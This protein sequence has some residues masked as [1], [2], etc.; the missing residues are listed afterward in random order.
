MLN[1]RDPARLLKAVP[2]TKTIQYKGRPVYAVPHRTEEVRVLKNLGIEAPAP[3][4]SYYDYPAQFTPMSHQRETV[5]FLTTNPRAYCLHGLGAGKTMCALWSYDWLRREGVVN[6]LLVVSPL[7]TLEPAWGREIFLNM[8]HLDYA[9]LHGSKKKRLALLE[10]TEYDIYVINHDGLSTPE[11]LEALCKRE[12]I[13]IVIIDELAGYRN[14]GTR[15]WKC[16]NQFVN[17]KKVKG[18]PDPDYPRREW[19]W[20]LTGTPIPNAPTDAWGQCMMLNPAR[21]PRSMTKFRDQVMRQITQFKWIP[22]PDALQ[23]VREAMQPAI[24][25]S[26]E[27]CI[28]L[29]PTTYITR[30]AALTKEQ[31]QAY[32]SMMRHLRAITD[33]GELT[34]VNSAVKLGRLLQICAGAS[35]NAAGDAVPLPCKPR[36]DEA[37]EVIQEAEAKVIVF[38]PYTA[39]LEQVAT[40]LC[41][42]YTVEVVQGSTSKTERDRIF[43]AFQNDDAPHVLVANPGA[44]SHGLTLTAAD[45]IIWFAPVHSN[46]TWEQANGRIA[47]PGQTRNTRIVCLKGSKAEE[48]VYKRLKDKG[49]MQGLLLEMLKG[50]NP[51]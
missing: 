7:S 3:V 33:A 43:A 11:V 1:L 47:R 17:G 15:K 40:E 31:S 26:R 16:L 28:D 46:E 34:A 35:Y 21:V 10:S 39:A 24:R 6:K 32:E 49:R 48:R 45:T 50:E 9:V 37:V 8:P 20:G 13:D 41:K 4:A 12:D 42:K 18:V 22:K 25:F 44:T 5:E 19:A 36:L 29:P 14:K 2:H 38:V 51:D 23:T 30:D 27:E